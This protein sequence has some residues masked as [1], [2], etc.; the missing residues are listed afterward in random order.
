[1]L[2]Y[3]KFVPE[4]SGV[5]AQKNVLGWRPASGR[6]KWI[7]QQLLKLTFVLSDFGVP[8]R[9]LAL[10]EQFVIWD[11][12]NLLLRDYSPFVNTKIWRE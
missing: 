11:A 5:L 8:N 2:S 9:E 3:E 10:S 12:D 6:R 4:S 7:Y 1:M